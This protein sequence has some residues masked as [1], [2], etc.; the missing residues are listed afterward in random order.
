MSEKRVKVGVIGCGKISPQYFKGCA[1]FPILNVVASADIDMSRA[2]AKATEYGV[3]PCTDEELLAD[4]DIEIVVNL[5]WP[6][7]HTEVDLMAI[8]AGKHVH[9]EKPLGINRL[10]GRRT[11]TAAKAKGV[12]LGGAPDTFLGGG[13]QT[14]RKLI[15]E[16]AIGEPVG[17]V[18]FFTG[19]GPESW[20]PDP[21]TFYQVGG[22]PM[23]DMGPYYLTALVN[24][25]GPITRVTGSARAS[26]PER[27]ITSQP[28]NGTRVKVEVPTYVAGVMDFANGAVGTLITTFDV[29]ASNVP[30]I[31]IFGSEGS[32]GVPDPNIFGGAVLLRR[33]NET[34]WTEIPH[35]HDPNVGRGIGVAD[36]AYAL[37]SGR[38]HRCNSDLTYHVLDVMCAFEEASRS[39][40]HVQIK[41]TCTR[42]APLPTGLKPGELDW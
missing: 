9:S 26:F 4:P 31:E 3:R 39:G 13:I 24:L 16:G 37:R 17:A 42:P 18:A 27:L 5:T 1:Q 14:C 12:R 6:K 29:W 28:K 2:L 23:L 25:I 41:S 36:L 32:L 34:T 35:S 20:H 19:H 7:A 33:S 30:R 11:V 8:A 40:K 38:P 22:G 21:E 10:D 15:D